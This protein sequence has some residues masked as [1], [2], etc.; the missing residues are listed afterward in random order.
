MASTEESMKNKSDKSGYSCLVPD[1]KEN[2]FR[3]SA[4]SMMLTVRLLYMDF[5]C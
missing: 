4:V 3:F 2:V 1:L 5:L